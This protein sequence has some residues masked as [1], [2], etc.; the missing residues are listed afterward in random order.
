MARAPK[1]NRTGY[2]APFAGEE[3][4]LG[5]AS[6]PSADCL[7]VPHLEPSLLPVPDSDCYFFIGVSQC[8]GQVP[9][10][11]FSDSA[12]VA[13][14]HFSEALGVVYRE[15]LKCFT[16]PTVRRKALQKEPAWCDGGGP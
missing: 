14:A 10:I 7:P 11:G 6:F 1:R 5:L 12:G 9:G 4:A 8:F 16:A 13:V 2:R 15:K 3:A